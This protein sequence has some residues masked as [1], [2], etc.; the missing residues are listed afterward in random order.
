[1]DRKI[2]DLFYLTIEKYEQGHFLQALQKIL[3]APDINYDQLTCNHPLFRHLVNYTDACVFKNILSVQHTN[4]FLKN[5]L[6]S[7]P[8]LKFLASPFIEILDWEEKF[9]YLYGLD[10]PISQNVIFGNEWQNSFKEIKEKEQVEDSDIDQIVQLIPPFFQSFVKTKLQILKHWKIL[11]TAKPDLCKILEGKDPFCMQQPWHPFSYCLSPNTFQEIGADEI[12][13]LFLEPIEDLDYESLLAPFAKRPSILVFETFQALIQLLQFPSVL[14]FLISPQHA[15]YI[16]NQYPNLQIKILRTAKNR[17]KW[18]PLFLVKRKSLEEIMP[19]FIEAFAAFCA[20]DSTLGGDTPITNW[21]YHICKRV[22]F[23]IQAERYGKSRY[24]A[25]K[26]EENILNWV[27]NHKGLPPEELN[28]G[29]LAKDFLQETIEKLNTKRQARK[30]APQ[31]KIRLAHIVPQIVHINHAPTR[32]LLNLLSY[33]DRSWFD[34]FLISTERLRVHPDE[35]P[36]ASIASDSSNIRANNIL[37]QLNNAGVKI[38]IEPDPKTYEQ[39]A[40][41]IGKLLDELNIDVAI[42]H[43]PDEINLLTA[44]MTK[45]PIRILFEHGTIPTYPCFDFALLSSEESFKK[46]QEALKNLGIESF[47]LPFCIDVRQ[48]WM[49]EPFTKKELG[50]PEDSFIMT[51]ISNHLDAR[52]GSEICHTIGKIL[53]RCPR[54]YYAP[55]GRVN[56]PEKLREIFA[57]Y[58]VNSRVIFLGSKSNPSQYTRSMELYLNEFPFGSCLG[59]LDAM[60]SGCPVVSMY[61]EKGPPQAK[62]GATFFGM[63]HVITNCKSDDYTELACRLIEDAE[64][65]KEWSKHAL[66]R[67]E[68]F[69]D[70]KSYVCKFEKILEVWIDF[71]CS[72]KRNDFRG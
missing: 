70:V 44:S 23:K 68:K 39:T 8:Q 43:G 53:Q 60:G 36:N 21:L 62:Y 31:N 19:L 1:M 72:T 27:D 18:T 12:P 57:Q 25:L 15:I 51:T 7:D 49:K 65:Y 67:Y 9:L 38:H 64:L 56:N 42:F 4:L 28:L 32:L 47:Y 20:E 16:M 26:S 10:N 63:D 29:P 37:V 55:I 14:R 33:C 3:I 45:T 61:D 41:H 30:F 69:V 54:A 6:S 34:L 5:L 11:K 17:T 58:Q 48:S 2:D 13:L 50:F 40:E 35:Y 24:L 22:I 52:L 66:E 71:W 46:H 59:M